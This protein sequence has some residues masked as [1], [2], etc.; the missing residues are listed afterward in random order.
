MPPFPEQRAT[1]LLFLLRGATERLGCSP[2]CFRLSCQ[3]TAQGRD[4][5][6]ERYG[7]QLPYR[8]RRNPLLPHRPS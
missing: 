8:S 6:H 1:T 5:Q 3:D 2:I 4:M 7:D